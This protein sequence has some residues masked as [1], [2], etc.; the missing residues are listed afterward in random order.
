[1]DDMDEYAA[2]QFVKLA[3]TLFAEMFSRLKGRDLMDPRTEAEVSG[4]VL[5]AVREDPEL[6]DLAEGVSVF[7]QFRAMPLDDE[8]GA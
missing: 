6:E 4:E 8:P 5:R 2:E 7:K 1:M 3:N